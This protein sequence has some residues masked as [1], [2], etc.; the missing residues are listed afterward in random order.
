MK[1]RNFLTTALELLAGALLP[2]P[3]FKKL[4]RPKTALE[5]FTDPKLGQTWGGKL[6]DNLI[7]QGTFDFSF[8]DGDGCR[9]YIDI[10]T[11]TVYHRNGYNGVIKFKRKT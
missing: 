3:S 7:V 1:R 8:V 10:K 4:L 9:R 2:L 11:S 5:Q 6:A